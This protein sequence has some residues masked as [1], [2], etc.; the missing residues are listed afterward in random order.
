MNFWVDLSELGL[1]FCSL[2]GVRREKREEKKE[3]HCVKMSK[4]QVRTF[5][6]GAGPGGF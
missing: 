4:N 2:A 5:Y 6:I 3:K 1:G